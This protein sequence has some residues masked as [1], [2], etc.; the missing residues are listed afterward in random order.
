MYIFSYINGRKSNVNVN[1]A[2]TKAEK[3]TFFSLMAFFSKNRLFRYENNVF[4]FY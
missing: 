4:Y 3:Q 2:T 1:E